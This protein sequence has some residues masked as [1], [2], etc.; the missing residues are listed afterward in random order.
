MPVNRGH[1]QT[2]RWYQLCFVPTSGDSSDDSDIESIV[3]PPSTPTSTS[4]PRQELHQPESSPST[5]S[6]PLPANPE[7]QIDW[8]FPP[9]PPLPL[10]FLQSPPLRPLQTWATALDIELQHDRHQP[11][12][13]N[14]VSDADQ[15]DCLQVSID[16]TNA[17]S[18]GRISE[19]HET[20]KL[21][22]CPI[23]ME[24]FKVG[25][26]A[27][28]LPCNHTYC[29]EC[30]LRWLDNNKTCPICRFQ[31]D[32]WEGPYGSNSEPEILPPPPPPPPPPL[33]VVLDH[34]PW[35]YFFPF[36]SPVSQGVENRASDDSNVT[37][38]DSACD[39]LGDSHED[40]DMVGA[41]QSGCG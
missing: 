30:I 12:G 1:G 29:S 28:R 8:R 41:S 18:R 6:P 16:V 13:L 15:G 40:G 23:C 31:C 3:L 4:T 10:H 35:D 32:G 22:N 14:H 11:L 38:Y 21:S 9:P 7:P 20:A 19:L 27:C 34:S 25:G 39:E 36:D 26:Q 24:D 37:D 33:D 17:I 5:S 2:T